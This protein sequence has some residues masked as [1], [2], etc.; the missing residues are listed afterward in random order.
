MD[1]S[2]KKTG[3]IIASI[4]GAFFVIAAVILVVLF[5]FGY[6]AYRGGPP[7]VNNS[8]LSGSSPASGGSGSSSAPAAAGETPSPTPAQQAAIAGGTVTT[9]DGQGISWTLPSGWTKMSS[10]AEMFSY[11][12]PGTWEAGFLI[13]NIST[14][15]DSIPT[16]VSLNAMHQAALDKQKI[17]DYTEVRWLVID[18]VKGVQFLEKSPEDS[19]DPQRLQWQAY[20]S[21]NGQKQLI[22]LILSSSGK[23]FP[24]HVDALYGILY[25]TKLNT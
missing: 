1:S 3:C 10:S 14:M 11:K 21:H 9:W 19:S 23:G 12:S 6:Y 7:A 2:G 5:G 20:R 15:P 4:V 8:P 16:D 13:V 17:G 25:S 24:T 18:G 22:N